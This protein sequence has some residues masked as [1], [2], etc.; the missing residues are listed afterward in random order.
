MLTFLASSTIEHLGSIR[1]PAVRVPAS[2]LLVFG[3]ALAVAPHEQL[4]NIIVVAERY[5]VLWIFHS[6]GTA[7]HLVTD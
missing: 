3:Q 7:N 4:H 1:K 5:T 6:A 2:A